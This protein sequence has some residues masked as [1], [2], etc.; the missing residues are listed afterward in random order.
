MMQVGGKGIQAAI[1]GN[2][3]QPAV[4]SLVMFLVPKNIHRIIRYD[5][6]HFRNQ[7]LQFTN[8]AIGNHIQGQLCD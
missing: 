8:L 1:A 7:R 5:P 2:F 4:K 3:H 6:F